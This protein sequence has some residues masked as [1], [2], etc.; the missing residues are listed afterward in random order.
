MR[1]RVNERGFQGVTIEDTRDGHCEVWQSSAIDDTN[2]GMNNPG[3]SYVWLDVNGVE[4]RAHLDRKQVK[5]LIGVL[6]HWLKTGE[7]IDNEQTG[8]DG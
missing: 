6:R 4:T 2:R 8:R 1:Q 5:E 7:L 3:S